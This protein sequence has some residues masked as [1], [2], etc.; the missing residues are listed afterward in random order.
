MAFM[1]FN[2]WMN[3]GRQQSY[4]RMAQGA[5]GMQQAYWAPY[6][7]LSNSYYDARQ[8]NEKRY[9]DILARYQ[10]MYDR[11]MGMLRDRGKQEAADIRSGWANRETQGMQDLVGR[12]LAG[13]TIAPTMKAGYQRN[14]NADLGRLDERLRSEMVGYDTSMTGRMLDFMERR[15]DTYPN[16]GMYYPM[17][18]QYGMYGQ[19]PQGY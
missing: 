5:I 1:P 3:G 19:R 2:E 9:A 10:Q 15:D 7:A 12:G 8:A 13:T 18:Q 14:M 6:K 11:N 17:F 4:D 16:F